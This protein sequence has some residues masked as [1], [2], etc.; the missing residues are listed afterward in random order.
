MV[1][2]PSAQ[3][4]TPDPGCSRGFTQSYKTPSSQGQL[5]A[6]EHTPCHTQ[7]GATH[8]V[9]IT[10]SA[11][12]AW[13]CI[14]GLVGLDAKAPI[15]QPVAEAICLATVWPC[16]C[17]PPVGPRELPQSCRQQQRQQQIR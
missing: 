9:P 5:T 14:R 8:L 1:T 17:K 13:A 11:V 2:Q 12:M 3:I 10:S 7:Q 6:T 15:L 16:L 4:P